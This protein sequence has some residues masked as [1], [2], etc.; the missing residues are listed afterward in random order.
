[1]KEKKDKNI[2]IYGYVCNR[3]VKLWIRIITR[4]HGS[5]Y[6]FIKKW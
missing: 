2:W 1:M 3:R 4:E 5:L 6:Y